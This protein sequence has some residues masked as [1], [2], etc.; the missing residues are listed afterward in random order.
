MRVIDK[1]FIG[2]SERI[3][4]GG[5]GVLQDVADQALLVSL[6]LLIVL[7]ELLVVVQQ[8]LFVKQV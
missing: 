3:D 6:L 1:S 7:V 5:I 4:V 8:D 2:V